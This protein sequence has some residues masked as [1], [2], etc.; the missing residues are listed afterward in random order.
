VGALAN[1]GYEISDITVGNILRRHALPPAP[2]RKHTTTPVGEARFQRG[3]C[4]W[5]ELRIR[6]AAARTRIVSGG[7]LWPGRR[8]LSRYFKYMARGRIPEFESYDPSHAVV[9][10][11][12]LCTPC[13]TLPSG[14]DARCVRAVAAI[15]AWR[16]GPNAL[17]VPAMLGR[18]RRSVRPARVPTSLGCCPLTP[19]A[20]VLPLDAIYCRAAVPRLRP[21]SRMASPRS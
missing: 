15:S 12:A 1:L 8:E 20:G 11:A 14:P 16:L 2:E 21:K 4:A 10:S 18:A 9:S 17:A 3:G 7:W 5:P 13:L 19:A 6:N